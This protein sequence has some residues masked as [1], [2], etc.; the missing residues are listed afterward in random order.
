MKPK[1]KNIIHLQV[2][3]G[4]LC[5]VAVYLLTQY[6][7]AVNTGQA[8]TQP[9]GREDKKVA[10]TFDDGPNPQYTETLLD[11]L[12]ERDVK[13]TFFLI[14]KQVEQYPEIVERMYKE[15]HEIGNHTYDHVNLCNLS[16]AEVKEQVSRTNEAIMEITGVCPVYI[17]PPFGCWSAE[18]GDETGMIDVLWNVDPRDWET[19]NTETIIRR[20]LN[21][22]ED[23][24][25]ILFHDC[26]KS[27]VEAA[28]AVVDA[29]HERGYE[30]VGV[31]E[32]LFD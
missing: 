21:Q 32:I 1:S 4:T 31:E 15:G 17:R 18:L 19:N 29:L 14:G 10:I 16:E 24:D 30:F 22:V 27:S 26:S 28:L 12:K 6:F 5:I 13:A 25:I 23:H 20:V 2:W 3:I 7:L 8:E 11:G 9:S